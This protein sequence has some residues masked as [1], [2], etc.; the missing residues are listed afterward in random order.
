MRSY[1][2]K[3]ALDRVFGIL[4]LVLAAPL[5]LGI[6]VAV[7][8]EHPRLPLLFLDWVAGKDGRP[9]RLLKFRTMLPHPIDYGNRPEVYL[10]NPLITRVGRW[11]RRSKLDELPQLLH[12]ATGTM[13]FVGP[14]PMDIHRYRRASDFHRQRCVVRPGVTGLVQ[15]SGNT[16]MSWEVRM[17]K[18]L[19]YIANWSLALDLQ[20]LRRTVGVILFG[21]KVVADSLTSQRISDPSVRVHHPGRPH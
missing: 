15:V 7:K 20:I 3:E 18:D 16:Q 8:L 2:V 19:W 9:F 10:G 12:V 6:A 13:S 21:E 11:L 1:L 14:R 4:A 5:M 17:E